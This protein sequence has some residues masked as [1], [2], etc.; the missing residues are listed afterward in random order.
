MGAEAKENEIPCRDTRLEMK[1]KM[2]RNTTS[3]PSTQQD[4]SLR[5]IHMDEQDDIRSHEVLNPQK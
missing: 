3:G 1:K 5:M 2:S 4:D